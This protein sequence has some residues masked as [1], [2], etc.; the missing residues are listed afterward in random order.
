[1]DSITSQN[2]SVISWSQGGLDTQWAVKYWPSTR[3][4]TSNFIAQSP[5]F[6]GTVLA[7]ITCPGFP[8]L[9]VPLS[10]PFPLTQ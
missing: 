9:Y 8:Q 5:D 2:V 3:N 10:I 6:H 1:M 4:V 7:Y